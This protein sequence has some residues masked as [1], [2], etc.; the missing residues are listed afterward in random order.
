MSLYQQVL[1]AEA[2]APRLPPA[3]A[4]KLELLRGA[5][6][7]QFAHAHDRHQKFRDAIGIQNGL[8]LER[9][10]IFEG[11]PQTLQKSEDA[12]KR[13]TVEVERLKQKSQLASADAQTAG[14]FLRTIDD[15]LAD[16]P[17]ATFQP[18][19]GSA[20]PTRTASE[21]WPDV[22]TRLRAQ[23][24]D[25]RAERHRVRHA[26]IPAE[27]AKR[28]IRSEV[29]AMAERGAVDVVPVLNG[30]KLGWPV[31]TFTRGDGVA[32]T[33]NAPASTALIAWL[34]RDQLIARLEAEIDA[35]ADDSQAFTDEQRRKADA[36]LKAQ[37][38][39]FGREEEAA[40]CAA[41]REGTTLTRRPDA[42][43]RAVL[44]LDDS[45]PGL[46]EDE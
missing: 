23:L 11:N 16:R 1:E 45:L 2:S 29:D 34:Q 41:A 5:L 17:R 35:T 24:A 22:V 38:L 8:R 10:R 6:A 30:G 12:I 43:P 18:F 13:Q 3:A 19:T 39:A 33:Y 9:E 21:S 32:L 25:L 36:D 15:W 7:A 27:E 4:E 14:A 46:P 42:D 40:I 31:E 44:G 37:I 26:P 20:A 28:R